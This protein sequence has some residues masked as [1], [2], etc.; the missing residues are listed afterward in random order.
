MCYQNLG[1]FVLFNFKNY[2]CESECEY[3]HLNAGT[4]G[5]Q[6]RALNLQK[7]Y[8]SGC[9]PPN[10]GAGN[11]TWIARAICAVCV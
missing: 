4:C 6:K 1:S 8:Y 7:P 9:E 5:G 11:L 2:V 10:M 3:V